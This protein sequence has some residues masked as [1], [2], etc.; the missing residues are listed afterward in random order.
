MKITCSKTTEF[1]GKKTEISAT[2]EVNDEDVKDQDPEAK[3]LKDLISE[4]FDG[5][6]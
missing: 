4:I 2:V 1:Q 5:I 6:K 3:P